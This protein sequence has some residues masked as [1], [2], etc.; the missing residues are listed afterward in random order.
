VAN[1]VGQSPDG[2]QTSSG[3]SF[4]REP[5]GLPLAEAGLYRE[6]MITAVLDLERADRCFALD[7]LNAPPFLR[8]HWEKMMKA[9]KKRAGLRPR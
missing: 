8:P 3:Q 2:S 7:S 9:V 1:T 6:E 4:I 5:H